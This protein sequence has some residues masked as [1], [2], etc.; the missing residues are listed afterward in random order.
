MTTK[1]APQSTP[2]TPMTP[3]A[4]SRIQGATAKGNGGSVAKGSFAATA[5]SVAAK[6]GKR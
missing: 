5:Q 4:A 3:A 2:R 6:G 1:S